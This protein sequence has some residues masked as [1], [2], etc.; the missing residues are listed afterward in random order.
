MPTGSRPVPIDRRV[1]VAR[2]NPVVHRAD[3]FSALTV[4]N[5]EFAFTADVTGLQTFIDEYRTDFPLCTASH[6][7][8]HTTP[9][10]P[11]MDVSSLRYEPY[12]TYGRSVG[13]ATHFHGQQELCHWLRENPHRL[14]LGRIGFEL[15]KSDASLAASADLIDINQCLDLWTG[16]LHSQ[17]KFDG[18]PVKV[19]TCCH[20]SLDLL[21]VRVESRLLSVGRIR[22]MLAF[23]YGSPNVDMADWNH[24][25]QH[26]TICRLANGTAFLTR[27]IDDTQYFANLHFGDARFEEGGD[28]TYRLTAPS[29]ILQFSILFSRDRIDQALPVFQQ[30]A[31]ASAAHWEK[32]WSSGATIDLSASTAPQAEELQRRIILSQYQTAIHCSGSLPPAE[33]GLL[34]NSWYGKFH[35]EMHW[36]HAVHFA[37]WNRFSL[38][39]RSLDYYR[40]ILKSARQIAAR[41]G[42]G[43]AR[44]PKMVGPEGRDSP[45]P[46]GPLLI[47]QQPHP[48]YY[49]EMCYRNNPTEH[50]LR[51][52]ESIVFESAQFLC[53]FAHLDAANNRFVLGPPLK[54]VPENT[55]ARTTTNPTFELAYVRFALRT[56]LVW[57]KR[58][59]LPPI[60]QWQHV[61]SRLSALPIADGVYIPQEGTTDACTKWNVDHPAMLGALGMQPGDGV[62]PQIMRQTLHRVLDKWKWETAWGWDFPMAAMT[63]ARLDEPELAIAALMI[64]SPKNHYHP[65]GHNYQRPALT[66]YLPGNGAL[67]AAISLMAGGCDGGPTP[68][69]PCF[70]KNGK[71]SVRYEGFQRWI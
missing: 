48:I 4:G 39:S 69:V 11:G 34:F 50:V 28:H 63:A 40:R 13:Y 21:A 32:F 25:T 30:S 8:W 29:V 68:H 33:T 55:D 61:L 3:P 46:I 64:D 23:P 59:N 27:Q 12:D 70:P 38:F 22:V 17:F 54:T 41:Q 18:E 5:G 16:M 71:W 1:V 57:R 58:L 14:H 49:A 43:G 26:Q 9:P 47:W 52:W 31:S 42:Y 7:A 60:D 20:P 37:A 45:S 56:A 66:A 62:D 24:P 2:H 51:N 53:D 10:P 6:W 44:W 15:L 65:N 36:W 35:L 67:L 19:W